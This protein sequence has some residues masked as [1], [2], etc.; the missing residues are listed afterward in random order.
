DLLD[1][2]DAYHVQLCHLNNVF[3]TAIGRFYIQQGDPDDKAAI[4]VKK[5]VAETRA[6]DAAKASE[7]RT[8][9]NSAVK[10]WSWP[11]VLVFVNAWET[12]QALHKQHGH[13][14]PSFLYLPDG[15]V[16][17]TCVVL[18]SQYA[19]EK[20]P[21]ETL[22]YT[23]HLIGGGYPLISTAQGALREGS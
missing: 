4:S 22:R 21:L 20:T 1:A 5:A 2:R 9:E 7:P 17:P 3:A 13:V 10:P 16:V 19:A 14:V 6:S 12:P 18:A 8:L 23:S 15:R 11:C